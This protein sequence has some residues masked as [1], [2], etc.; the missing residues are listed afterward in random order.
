[1][2]IPISE[3]EISRSIDRSIEAPILCAD[4]MHW[5]IDK[6]GFLKDFSSAFKAMPW[7]YYD[8][9]R[10]QWDALS[11]AQQVKQ[12]QA[13]IDYYLDTKASTE[14]LIELVKP[15]TKQA[16]KLRSIQPWRRR[17][18]C[19]FDLLF[20]PL[21]SLR[22]IKTPQFEQKVAE[23]DIRSL[24]RIFAETEDKLVSQDSFYRLLLAASRHLQTVSKHV[25]VRRLRITAHFMSVMAL[26]NLPG[27]N[28]P[29]GIHEDGADYIISALVINRKNV[30]GGSSQ[31]IEKGQSKKEVI[32]ERELS[33][34]EF[35]FQ[36]DTGEEHFYNTDLW[37]YVT[38]F[39]VKKPG[40]KAHRDIIGFDFAII[41]P[42]N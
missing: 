12:K 16:E 4:L 18:V 8:V 1:M 22:R 41:E 7:D 13:F 36:A 26:P 9:K 27:D 11:A 32:F 28:S 14:D 5:H 15:N 24:P 19:T 21:I 40:A 37:H 2:D 30:V 42:N 25:E 23:S 38:P 10:K 31:I 33:P 35:V 6:E 17:S 39:A 34:G 20:D 3:L 29:E